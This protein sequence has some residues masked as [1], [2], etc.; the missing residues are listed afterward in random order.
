MRK[1]LLVTY[2]F[3]PSAASGTHRL[4]GFARHLPSFGWQPIVVAP[5]SLPVEP[6]DPSLLS[7]LPNELSVHRVPYPQG[8]AS[9]PFRYFSPKGV[10]L[11]G[12]VRACA[13]AVRQH[14]PDA[15]LTSGPPHCVHLLGLSLKW[16][17]GLPWLADFRDP[18]ITNAVAKR[19]SRFWEAIDSFWERKVITKADVIIANAPL[20][21]ETLAA[22][23]PAQSGKMVSITNG[24]DPEDFADITPPRP[25]NG[26]LSI[27]HAGE[28]YLGRD[29]R[30]F[31][32]ALQALRRSGH[33]ANTSLHLR[34]LGRT[35]DAGLDFGAEIKRRGLAQLVHIDGHTSHPDTIRA[36][37]ESDILLLI[38]SPGRRIGVPAKLYEY[39]GARRAIFALAEPEGDVGRVLQCSALPHRIVSP[40]EPEKIPATLAELILEMTNR[41]VPAQ[42]HGHQLPF[43]RVELTRQLVGVIST[44]LKHL[45]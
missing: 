1:L 42:D 15:V 13:R 44:R 6:V 24:Y 22:A 34:F 26:S 29:P 7:R 11:P 12:A 19:Q 43:S 3:P 9:T 4:L 35:H 30:P 23:F 40:S 17:Y 21:C 39:I 28:L 2:H 38:D 33:L 37:G 27:L 31:L 45:P 25:V 20:A 18:W 8:R 41:M 10:W 5:H 14:R 16:R 36:M 32:D